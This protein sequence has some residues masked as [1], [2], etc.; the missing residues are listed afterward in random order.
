[1]PEGRQHA[2]AQ[3]PLVPTYRRRLVLLARAVAHDPRAGGDEQSFAAS[4]IVGLRSAVSVPARSAA[5]ASWRHWRSAVI[6]GKLRMICFVLRASYTCAWKLGV[7]SHHFPC[8][9]RR[10]HARRGRGRSRPSRHRA[11][12]GFDALSHR[13]DVLEAQENAG[14]ERTAD[15]VLRERRHRPQADDR[16]GVGRSATRSEEIA[17]IVPVPEAVVDDSAVDVWALLREGLARSGGRGARHRRLRRHRQASELA[18]SDR[19]RSSGGGN[20]ATTGNAPTEGGVVGDLSEAFDL[21]EVDGFDVN[22]IAARRKLRSLLR[23]RATAAV[24]H[25]LTHRPSRFSARR[26]RTSLRARSSMR[27]SRSSVTTRWRSSASGKT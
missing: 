11:E 20:V 15:R 22:G 3:V 16:S 12:R 14:A 5:Y 13:A 6:V 17:A 23:K 1:V 24:S 2:P 19:A 27:R 8:G 7:Q 25:S 21:R 4:S 26:S 10:L 9:C 18:G